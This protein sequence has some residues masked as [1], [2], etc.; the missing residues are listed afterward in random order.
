MI[1]QVPRC[2]NHNKALS[3]QLNKLASCFDDASLLSG[4]SHALEPSNTSRVGSEQHAMLLS[5]LTPH[6]PNNMRLKGNAGSA[7]RSILDE[8]LRFA[9]S[10]QSSIEKS[11][12]TT[13]A[14]L[15]ERMKVEELT[16]KVGDLEQALSASREHEKIA[17]DEAQAC[18][19]S[20]DAMIQDIKEKVASAWELEEQKSLRME[21]QMSAMKLEAE[22]FSSAKQEIAQ[23]KQLAAEHDDMLV[24]LQSKHELEQEHLKLLHEEERVTLKQQCVSPFPLY[25]FVTIWQLRG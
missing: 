17:L 3:E 8:N 5:E 4:P 2:D 1:V 12:Q 16:R 13:Q 25:V 21:A 18:K 22:E 11:S 23:F 15:N 19:Q 24:R 9:T 7:I 10:W 20:C 6:V 14:L